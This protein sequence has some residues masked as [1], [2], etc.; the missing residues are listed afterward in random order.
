MVSSQW[1]ESGRGSALLLEESRRVRSALDSIFGD[2]FLQIG[3]WG[4]QRFGQY[5]RTKRFSTLDECRGDGVD[6]VTSPECMGVASD[7]VDVVLLPHVLESIDDPHGVLREVDRV[8][9]SDGHVIILGL[10]P[11]SLWGLRHLLSRRRFPP[12]VRRLI[13]EHRLRDWLRLLNFSVANS[14]FQ[15]F[16]PPLLRR[17]VAGPPSPDAESTGNSEARFDRATARSGGR[18][19]RAAGSSWKAARKA[20]RRYAPFAG[21]YIVVARKELFTM[22]PVRPVWK[23]RRRLVGGLV[24][25]TTRNIA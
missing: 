22:T 20:W 1:F 14:S 16:R 8:L 17:G 24:N 23:P 19:I 13:P 4:G 9:R 18:F 3:R 25:P 15:H 5:A 11:A 7:S 10:N 2:Q 12:G 21:A 6:F